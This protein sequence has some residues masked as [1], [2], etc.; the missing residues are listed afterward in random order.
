MSLYKEAKEQKE[1]QKK[2]NRIR[3]A[4]WLIVA[5]ALILVWYFTK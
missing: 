3:I 4:T 2:K 5:V 1:I